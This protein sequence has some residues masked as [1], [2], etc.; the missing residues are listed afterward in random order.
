MRFEL[1]INA[2]E[3][4]PLYFEE[5]AKDGGPSTAH[6]LMTGHIIFKRNKCVDDVVQQAREMIAKGP[7]YDAKSLIN[8]RYMLADRF[9]NGLDLRE[10]DPA[11][12]LTLINEAITGMLTYQFK[13]L[14]K[15]IPR[16]KDLLAV[17]RRDDPN[18]AQLVELYQTAPIDDRFTIA[19]TIADYTLGTQGFFEWE[20]NKDYLD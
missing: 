20:S 4:L 12:G 6:M 5:E 17:L 2:V 16:H 13:K 19:G 10:R 1:F 7:S 3:F 11:M 9:E 8:E 18:L 15:W 14:D